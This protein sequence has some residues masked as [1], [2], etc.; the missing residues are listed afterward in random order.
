MHAASV[1]S[2]NRFRQKA[3]RHPH[4]CSNLTRNKFIKLKLVGRNQFISILLVF[5]VVGSLAVF[6]ATRQTSSS[7]LIPSELISEKNSFLYLHLLKQCRL[8]IK[9]TQAGNFTKNSTNTSVCGVFAVGTRQE[10]KLSITGGE[11]LRNQH[12]IKLSANSGKSCL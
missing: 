2:G 5:V 9:S 12:F 8:K 7:V 10:V 4:I 3:G 6:Q 11:N 1:Y